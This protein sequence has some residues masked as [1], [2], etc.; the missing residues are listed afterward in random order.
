MD[1]K[2]DDVCKAA[3]GACEQLLLGVEKS[4][5][6]RDNNPCMSITEPLA[7]HFSTH[8]NKLKQSLWLL[9]SF[10]IFIRATT[11]SFM[12]QFL[13]LPHTP[14]KKQTDY[15][16]TAMTNRVALLQRKQMRIY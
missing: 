4:L 15:A 1:V 8:V 10:L 7:F 9:Q 12:V 5:S 6:L 14:N 16:S 2:A 11:R 3:V 13:F